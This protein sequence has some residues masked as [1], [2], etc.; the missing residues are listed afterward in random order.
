M[1]LLPDDPQRDDDNSQPN[2]QS[3]TQRLRRSL[4][5]R[6]PD[7]IVTHHDADLEERREIVRTLRWNRRREQ[8][9]WLL[10]IISS[11]AAAAAIERF[12]H[13]L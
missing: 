12:L 4:F 2:R 6:S 3:R 10:T 11:G 1:L 9:R 13:G 8:L 5:G 7:E